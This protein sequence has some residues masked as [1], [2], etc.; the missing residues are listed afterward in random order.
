MQIQALVTAQDSIVPSALL[1]HPH[2]RHD[3]NHF[4]VAELNLLQ[5]TSLPADWFKEARKMKKL[6]CQRFLLKSYHLQ[7]KSSLVAS[8]IHS[9]NLTKIPRVKT[10]YTLSPTNLVKG[11]QPNAACAPA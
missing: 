4:A 9:E 11:Y 6:K 3:I 7:R 2:L 8:L 1:T 5:N 10:K